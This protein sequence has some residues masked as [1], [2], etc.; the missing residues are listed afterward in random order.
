M[1]K[2]EET[3]DFDEL[4]GIVKPHKNECQARIQTRRGAKF[5]RTVDIPESRRQPAPDF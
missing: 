1:M 5:D 4:G 2:S 3:D